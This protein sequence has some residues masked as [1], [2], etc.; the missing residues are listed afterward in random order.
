M[1]VGAVGVR[2]T[3]RIAAAV[4]R[5]PVLWPTA[6]RQVG[7]TARPGWWRRPPFLPL[8]TDDYLHFRTVTQYG[9]EHGGN[10]RPPRPDDV[11]D[12]L[13]WCREWERSL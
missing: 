5:R 6:L 13:A 8:P 4:A 7:R 11:V 12:Y 9:T 10:D 1:S 2:N 3:V